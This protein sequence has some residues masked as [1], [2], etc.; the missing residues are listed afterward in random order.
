[1]TSGR[2]L[3]TNT[4]RD[5]S[6]PL[7]KSQ[8]VWPVDAE[9]RAGLAAGLQTYG[10]VDPLTEQVGVPIV[11]GVFLDHVDEYPA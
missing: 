5:N 10:S 3:S 9:A 8:A 11:S 7:P 4:S 1:M 2:P 6:C